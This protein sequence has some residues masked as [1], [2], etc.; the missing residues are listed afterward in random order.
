MK[1]LYTLLTL[2]SLSAWGQNSRVF[3]LPDVGNH[4]YF[5]YLTVNNGLSQNSVTS[6]IQDKS[7]FIWIGTWDG[8]NRFDGFTI[9]SFRHIRENRNSLSDNRISCLYEDNAGRIL[10]GTQSGEL[11]IFN[12]ATATFSR[13]FITTGK[14]NAD[15]R[16]LSNDR[17]GNLWAGS[18][19]GLTIIH[20]KDSSITR[21]LDTLAI[22]RMLRDRAG[23]LWIGTNQG[24]YFGDHRLLA[25]AV[26]RSLAVVSAVPRQQVT[27]LYED[28][29]GV[30]WVGEENQLHALELQQDSPGTGMAREHAHVTLTSNSELFITGLQQD[31]NGDIWATTNGDGMYL[32]KKTPGH[33]LFK[34]AHYST[35][36]PFCNLAENALS[37]LVIDRS[38]VLW[39]G[40]YQKGVNYT[41]L[42]PASFHTFYPLL[43]DKTGELGF[44]GKFVTA[45]CEQNNRLWIGTANEGLFHYNYSTRQLQRCETTRSEWISS[46]LLS[47]KGTVWI[48]T[49]HG[50]YEAGTAAPLLKIPGLNIHGIAEDWYG[51][52]WLTTWKGV[53]V[54][55]PFTGKTDTLTIAQ[56]LS[57]N[58]T[59][60]VY[61]DPVFPQMWVS[62]IGKGL[63][64]IVYT[65]T[66]KHRITVTYTEQPG[67]PGFASNYIWCIYREGKN[68]M[69]VG[70]DAGLDHSVLNDSGRIIAVTHYLSDRKIL[71]IQHDSANSFWL[72]NSQGL[73][74]YNPGTGMFKQYTYKDGLQSNTFTEASYKTR[75]GILLFGGIN[76]MNYFNPAEIK[77][78]PYPAQAAVTSLKIFSREIHPGDTLHGRVVLNQAINHTP[79]LTLSYKD[80]NFLLSFAALHYALP[81]KNRFR[82][83]LAGYDKDWIVTDPGE[84]TAAYS[85]LPAGRYV[86]MLSAS[87]N[88]GIWNPRV[89][90]I[91]IIIEPAPWKTW[92]ARCLYV[93][94]LLF[95]IGAAVRYFRRKNT[96]K[97]QLYQEKLEKEKVTE[98]NE[99]KLNFFTNITHELRTPLHLIQGPISELLEKE[100]NYDRFTRFRL[101]LVHNNASRLY[102]LVNQVLDLRK[103]SAG[104]SR[105][106]V[107][108]GDIVKTV[109]DI[110]NS[111]NWLADKK[112]IRFHFRFDQL[113]FSAWF[114]KDKIEK[115]VANLLD[116]AF[117]HTEAGGEITVEL[118]VEIKQELDP[119]I[120]IIVQDSGA[121]IRPEEADKIFELFYQGS[122]HTTHGNGIGLAFAKMLIET[123]H[124]HISIASE[125]GKGARF[126]VIFPVGKHHYNS[127]ELFSG[128]E[129]PHTLTP[130]RPLARRTLHALAGNI[131]NRKTVLIIEDNDDQRAYIKEHIG[132]QLEVLEATDGSKGLAL[133]EACLPDLILTDL[134][135]PG[136]DGTTLCRKLKENPKTRHIPVII[137]SVSNNGTSRQKAFEA[138]ACDFIEKPCN[139]A[140]LLLKMKNTI[141]STQQMAANLYQ[142]ALINPPTPKAPDADQEL[143]KKV[144]AIIEQNIAEPGFSVEALSREAAMSRMHLHR[145]IHEITGKT[146]SEL[147][148]EIRIKRAAKLLENG[149]MRISEV[150]EETGFSNHHLFN[151]YFKE[152]YGKSPREYAKQGGK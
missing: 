40:C 126:V 8:L 35:S 56:G 146:S 38:G 2:W 151:K 120:H 65:A 25:K 145:R 84:R 39:A 6:I 17:E 125:P 135:M 100:Q 118:K 97:N 69:W 36:A 47:R 103:V 50:L 138:G 96:L 9:T 111:F 31:H 4:G 66:G 19:N 46:L 92:W 109:A 88:D 113:G 129:P 107:S 131:K 76:G 142:E 144:V 32:L 49:S 139:Y 61:A 37:C 94:L 132:G 20:K 10:A 23:N 78:N 137:H 62:T 44:K 59:F 68:Q 57:S 136:M 121:G 13:L 1:Q 22:T 70:T 112:D 29:S 110:K 81:E 80:N 104:S 41:N 114:D 82:Y 130:A 42:S 67:S 143:L 71:S 140:L 26:S 133:A 116:N 102:S 60:Q 115:T 85:N 73:L 24:L 33:S 52:L 87:N 89:H 12:P 43:S 74:R 51:N 64:C 98:L 86:F 30:I 124:G 48:G 123:H 117:K 27:A 134:M 101:E 150:M 105:L 93:M 58:T 3:P 34:A 91:E 90:T 77:D 45:L 11:N 75:N 72:G 79:R 108:N 55:H 119:F 53:I 14:E 7:G 15:L 54:Y 18:S 149:S 147:I 122:H 148:R 152:Y 95:A 16:T 106:F 28:G 128:Q 5:N 21:L 127:S 63:N 99:M 141:E 83:R